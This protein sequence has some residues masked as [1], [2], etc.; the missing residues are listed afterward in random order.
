MIRV[1][2]IIDMSRT[3]H[4]R[5]RALHGPAF[6]DL[7]E[8]WI[9]LLDQESQAMYTYHTGHKPDLR[10]TIDITGP[11]LRLVD[12]AH[13]LGLMDRPHVGWLLAALEERCEQERIGTVM[14]YEA[15][16]GAEEK[17]KANPQVETPAEAE[18]GGA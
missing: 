12:N 13:A 5:L 1:G 18:A 2:A 11:L 4:A 7:I 17:T 6:T 9:S 16:T 14:L 15:Q 3:E 8:P 10:T